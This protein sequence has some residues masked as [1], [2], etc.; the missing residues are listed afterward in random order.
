MDDGS[1]F[2]GYFKEGQA[3]GP[4]CLHHTSGEAFYIGQIIANQREGKGVFE[5]GKYRYEG[6]WSRNEPHGFGS[7]NFPNG[8]YF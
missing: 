6:D 4:R 7:Q 1:I 3:E 2:R 5:D 8:D